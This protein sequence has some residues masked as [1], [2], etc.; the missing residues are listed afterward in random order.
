MG[1]TDFYFLINI[2]TFIQLSFNFPSD[3]M[4]YSRII[5]KNKLN[6][7]SFYPHY[8]PLFHPF[9]PTLSLCKR[10]NLKQQ[11]QPNKH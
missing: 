1:L 5:N 2:F 10:Q 11:Q 3:T 8:F 9:T 6:I 7:P 4:K